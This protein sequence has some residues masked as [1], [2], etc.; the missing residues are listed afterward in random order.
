MFV[1][2]ANKVELVESAGGAARTIATI[3]NA[4]TRMMIV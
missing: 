4:P 3:D 1:A 2:T